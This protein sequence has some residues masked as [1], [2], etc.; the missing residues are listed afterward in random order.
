MF[1]FNS[2]LSGQIDQRLDSLEK[3]YLENIYAPQDKLNILR[4]LADNPDPNKVIIYS[5]ELIQH[6]KELD[7]LD[8]LMW[9]YNLKGEALRNKG[10]LSEA[11][12]VYFEAAKIAVELEADHHIGRFDITIADVYSIM[13][14]HKNAVN[15]YKKAISIHRKNDS[16]RLLAIALENLGDEYLNVSK[17]D[18]ALIMFEESGLLFKKLSYFPGIGMNIGNK[19]IAYALQGRDE[20]ANDNMEHAIVILEKLQ[21]YDAIAIY[22]NYISDLYLNQNKLDLALDYANRSLELAEKYGFKDQISEANFQMSKIYELLGE[23][24]KSLKYYKNYALYKDS[25]NNIASVQEMANIRTDFEV[26]QKQLEVD[27]LNQQKRNQR[28]VVISTIIALILIIA[29]AIGLYRR[30]NLIEKTKRIIEKEKNRSDQ[31]LL[32]ILP[33]QTAKELKEYG[34]VEAK[35]FNSVSVLFTDF[36]GFTMSSEDLSPEDLVRSVDFYYRKF[37]EIIKS[38]GLEKIKTIGDAYMAA[39]GLPF[40]SDD[41]AQKLV[42]A[43]LEIAGFVNES[44]ALSSNDLKRFDIRIGIHSGP[45]VAGV[46]GTNKFAYDIWGDTVNIASRMESTSLQGKVNISESTY[47]LIKDD[48]DCEYRGEIHA[49]NKGMLKMYFV[50]GP[51]SKD[52]HPGEKTSKQGSTIEFLQ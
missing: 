39:G 15:Y 25:V 27:L 10:D 38:Y 22:L 41:H 48:F 11:L 42:T 24:A 29:L 5:D 36:Q 14:N 8:K 47:E 28:I 43:A 12:S 9:A 35:K 20:M 19:G 17:P 33:E 13:G 50:N 52:K 26:S 32:N 44:K 3:L 31:L 37:D 34:K 1:L 40:P 4:E 18:S 16:I 2:F 51:K 49:K 23:D 46:V 21:L 30:N 6:A 45:V 7:S